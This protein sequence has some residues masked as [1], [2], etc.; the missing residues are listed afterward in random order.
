MSASR[1]DSDSPPPDDVDRIERALGWR[2]TAFRPATAERGPS[3]TAARWIVADHDGP[4]VGRRSAFVKIGATDLTA[5][6]TR[7]EYRN[8]RSLRGWFLPDVLGFDDDGERPVLALEDLSAADWPPPWTDERVAA[9]RDALA[10]IRATRPP[11]HLIRRNVDAGADWQAV[12]AEPAPFL[13]LGL[14]TRAWLDAAL[15]ALIAAA[16]SAPLAG[17][18]LVHLDI[19]S[20]NLCIRDGRAIVIDWN[21]AV[22]ANPDLDVAFWLP[23]LHA[24]GGPTPES[25]LP[26]AHE[27]AAWVAG[28]F[29]AGAGNAPIVEAPHVRPLQLKQ[30]RTALPWAARALG[31][32]PP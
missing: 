9:V 31:L 5:D 1:Q 32:P 13:A 20:D 3:A 17:E 15:P 2:P 6:W 19:R 18:A 27:L 8:Y 22:V 14:C 4:G 29:C 12:A 10:A 24:E 30:S 28:F 25:I 21:H 7:T 16:A 23:S 11:D 26:D